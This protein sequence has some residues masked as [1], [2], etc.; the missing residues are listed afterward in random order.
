MGMSKKVKGTKREW[1]SL[2]LRAISCK[3]DHG[4]APWVGSRMANDRKQT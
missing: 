2:R 3:F 1:K 4:M